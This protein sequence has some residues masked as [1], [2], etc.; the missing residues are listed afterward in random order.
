MSLKLA[1]STISKKPLVCGDTLCHAGSLPVKDFDKHVRA[2]YFKEYKTIY[3]RFYN[4]SGEYTF[5]NDSDIQRS[6]KVC[7]IALRVFIEEGIIPKK[8]K[9]LYWQTNRKIDENLIKY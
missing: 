3:F 8:S 9:V 4:P 7:D 6:F 5:I 1:Y 2:I